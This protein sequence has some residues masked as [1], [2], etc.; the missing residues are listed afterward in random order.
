MRRQVLLRKRV[1]RQGLGHGRR[2]D[3]RGF[4]LGGWEILLGVNGLQ[5]Q[6]APS[7]NYAVGSARTPVATM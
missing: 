1:V 4:A 3:L 5:H 2:N 6:T 7:R